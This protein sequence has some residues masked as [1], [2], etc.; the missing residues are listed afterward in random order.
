MP[1][2]WVNGRLT[3]CRIDPPEVPDVH[4]AITIICEKVV[5][6]ITDQWKG[7]QAEKEE[8]KESRDDT[9]FYNAHN[10]FVLKEAFHN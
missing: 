7:Q 5:G 9:M 8:I 1:D 6:E 3:D 4:E 2:G 10:G